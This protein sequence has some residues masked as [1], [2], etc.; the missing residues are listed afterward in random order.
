MEDILSILEV[1]I[2]VVAPLNH[3]M[4]FGELGIIDG[5]FEW[6]IS[7][8]ILPTEMLACCVS[9]FLELS[10]IQKTWSLLCSSV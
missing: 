2:R 5:R 7:F 9:L 3:D 10:W 1:E 4:I 8:F 6:L